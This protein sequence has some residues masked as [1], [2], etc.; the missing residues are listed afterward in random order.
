[1]GKVHFGVVFVVMLAKPSVAIRGERGIG[2]LG[3][4]TLPEL[5]S[6]RDAME[7]WSQLLVDF[8]SR[9]SPVWQE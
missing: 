7:T 9:E 5:I 1:V 2:K 3:F 6:M 8:L 4:R